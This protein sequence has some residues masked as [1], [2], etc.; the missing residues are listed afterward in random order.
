MVWALGEI[1]D[2]PACQSNGGDAGE[3]GGRTMSATVKFVM[4]AEVAL[5]NGGKGVSFGMMTIFGL[6]NIFGGRRGS[7]AGKK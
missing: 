4:A 5:G 6:V 2:T 3:G 1:F 7:L